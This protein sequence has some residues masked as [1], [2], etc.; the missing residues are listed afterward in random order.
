MT[1][2]PKKIA[3]R[4][5]ATHVGEVP[6]AGDGAFGMARLGAILKERL[7]PSPKGKEGEKGKGDAAVSP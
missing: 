7:Q 3:E 5:G 6:D 1:L 4:L 2:D